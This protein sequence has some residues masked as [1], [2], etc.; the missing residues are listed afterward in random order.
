MEPFEAGEVSPVTGFY[1]M[2]WGQDFYP[3]GRVLVRAGS[4]FPSYSMPGLGICVYALTRSSDSE[5]P[6]ESETDV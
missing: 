2:L 6:D 3:S 5:A 1:D 4:T